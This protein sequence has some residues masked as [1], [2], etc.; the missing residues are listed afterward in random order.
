MVALFILSRIVDCRDHHARR[1]RDV[2][3]LAVGPSEYS[4][5]TILQVLAS[6]VCP[7]LRAST[8]KERKAKRRY[9]HHLATMGLRAKQD[10]LTEGA[11]ELIGILLR[12]LLAKQAA[13]AMEN[14]PLPHRYSRAAW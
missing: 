12:A 2:C 14:L 13:L 4:V 3:P 1:E 10:S 9:S 7:A 8:R 5:P 11:I 6:L